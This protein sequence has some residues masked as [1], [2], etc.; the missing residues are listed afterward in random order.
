MTEILVAL[1]AVFLA[2]FG[3]WFF[4]QQKNKHEREKAQAEQ[5]RCYDR[6]KAR[7]KEFGNEIDRNYPGDA[8]G[9]IVA[10]AEYVLSPDDDQR[11]RAQED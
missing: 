2:A 4:S 3:G 1:G 7:A 5:D 11:S 9:R 8:L 10:K 6:T